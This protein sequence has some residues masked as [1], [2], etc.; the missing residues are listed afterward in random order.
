MQRTVQRTAQL[1][2]AHGTDDLWAHG[3]IPLSVIQKYLNFQFSV[4]LDLFG[5]ETSSNA[6]AYFTAGL[7]GRWMETRRDDD[8]LLAGATMDVP[9]GGERCHHRQD[10]PRC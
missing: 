2:A 8:H 7:K 6:A 10:R 9:G 4:S 3:G 5:S 1:L